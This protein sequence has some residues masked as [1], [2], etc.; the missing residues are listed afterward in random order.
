MSKCSTELWKCIIRLA[1]ATSAL[2]SGCCP[3]SVAAFSLDEPGLHPGG[4]AGPA[5]PPHPHPGRWLCRILRDLPPP[6]A[7]PKSLFPARF[8]G[9]STNHPPAPAS[10]AAPPVPTGPSLWLQGSLSGFLGSWRFLGGGRG[11]SSR[12]LLGPV[13][14]T[15][16]HSVGRHGWALPGWQV[17]DG[18]GSV[19]GLKKRLAGEPEWAGQ[20]RPS[21][22][23]HSGSQEA[24]GEV[25]VDGY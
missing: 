3:T 13:P 5:S 4:R 8:R 23:R 1:A 19:L 6:R 12:F 24:A 14:P 22:S 11:S 15:R 18:Q 25:N 7:S 17:H 16:V 9:D 10:L 2:S 21:C 20:D